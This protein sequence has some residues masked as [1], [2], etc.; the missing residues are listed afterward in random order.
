MCLKSFVE[1][2]IF[3]FYETDSKE[4]VTITL[5]CVK[6]PCIRGAKGK[7][8]RKYLQCFWWF[9]WFYIKILKV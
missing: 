2:A 4:Y 5:P 8:R 9:E 1:A 6:Q 7:V 3:M